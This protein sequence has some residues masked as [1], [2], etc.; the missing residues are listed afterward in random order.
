MPTPPHLSFPRRLRMGAKEYK[1][2]LAPKLKD[3]GE[4]E[5]GACKIRLSPDQEPMQ[6]VDTYL[7]EVMHALI[8]ESGLNPLLENPPAKYKH[9][10]E[11]VVRDLATSLISLFSENPRILDY[12]KRALK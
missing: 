8:Y 3:A 7:H 4:T 10:E 1:V 11:V 9:L 2:E 5:A 6:F 12:L